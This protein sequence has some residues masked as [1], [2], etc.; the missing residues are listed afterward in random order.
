MWALG[1]LKPLGGPTVKVLVPTATAWK[2]ADPAAWFA[3]NGTGV[4]IVPVAGVPLV[5]GTWTVR[6]PRTDCNA[7]KVS[8]LGSSRPD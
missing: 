2:V 6:P 3:E 1:V 5:I 4:V 7:T 8:V